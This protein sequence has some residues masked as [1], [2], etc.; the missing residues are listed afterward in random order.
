MN[1]RWTGLLVLTVLMLTAGTAFTA[2][3]QSL[4]A[5][6][7]PPGPD[8]FTTIIIDY[9]ATTWWMAAWENNEVYCSI[10]TDHDGPPTPS[11]V[12][13]DCGVEIYNYW[14]TQPPCVIGDARLCEG[15]YVYPIEQQAAQK[16][17]A[18][19]LPAATAWLSLI[20]CQPVESVSTTV[21][22]G[23]PSLVVTGL[24]PLPN[25][26]ILRVEGTLG[27]QPFSCDA[28]E[29]ILPLAGTDPAGVDMEFWAYSSYG[30]STILYTAQVRAAQ[31]DVGDPDQLYWYIDVLSTQW[32]G[33]PPATCSESWQSFPPVG[34]APFWL[35]TPVHGE[36]LASDIPY[37]YLAANLIIQ[38]VVDAQHCADGGLIPGGGV[39]TCGLEAARPAVI[40]WQNQF[41]NLILSVAQET[42]VPAH[43]LK[44]LFARESQFWPGLFQGAADIG[45]GQLTEDG[46][47]TTLL[48][49]SSFYAQ[50]CPLVLDGEVCA[51]GYIYL[52]PIERDLLRQALVGSVNASCADCPLGLNLSQADF[53]IGVFAHTML[54]NC[55]QAGRIVRN[56]TGQ[57]PGE[58]AS[59]EDL[60]KFTLVNY[61]AG[62][63]CLGDA[64]EG[65][66][67]QGLALTWENIAPFLPG[68]CSSAVDYVNDIAK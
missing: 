64:L 15:F 53:S 55:D 60:W 26:T 7:P 51:K 18:A 11:E 49:N 1:K 37:T 35:S 44:N 13:R 14:I 9:T 61:H 62:P 50:F 46:A 32:Q 42:S 22:E 5:S 19:E 2:P 68:A 43:L 30:D 4:S 34:G 58:A 29:C 20:D 59:Y 25:E 65:A 52:E 12:Y 45:L 38:G 27:G 48:W 3:P 36:D 23:M 41:D 8:R 57:I 28:V 56:I 21:C 17:I 31:A 10:I 33:Q 6:N 24:E 39:N 47:D 66:D 67:L 40:E 54:A 16:E 63:G